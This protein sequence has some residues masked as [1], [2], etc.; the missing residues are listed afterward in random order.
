M[1]IL[2]TIRDSDQEILSIGQEVSDLKDWLDDLSGCTDDNF[3]IG[4]K[5]QDGR[6]VAYDYGY[7][8]RS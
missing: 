1:Q 8:P 7:Q 5:G 2:K 4:K 6:I 3:Q